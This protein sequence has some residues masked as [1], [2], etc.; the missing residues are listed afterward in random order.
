MMLIWLM[1]WKTLLAKGNGWLPSMPEV[2]FVVLLS[3]MGSYSLPKTPVYPLLQVLLG[4]A[5]RLNQWLNNHQSRN[6]HP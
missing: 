3:M 5:S 6:L 4:F 1:S 2:R